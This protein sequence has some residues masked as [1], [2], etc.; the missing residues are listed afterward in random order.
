[1]I[2]RQDLK[3]QHFKKNTLPAKIR[4]L[5]MCKYKAKTVS[6]IRTNKAN[7]CNDK[8]QNA[9]QNTA[10]EDVKEHKTERYKRQTARQKTCFD[11]HKSMPYERSRILKS[12]Q[13]G[14]EQPIKDMKNVYHQTYS[15]ARSGHMQFVIM[16][17][18]QIIYLHFHTTTK[19]RE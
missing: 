11:K 5:F 12:A 13:R 9:T 8:R 14:L 17:Q 2:L 6:K 16:S 19:K 10:N 18:Q 1:M 15:A 3:P 4:D 7:M